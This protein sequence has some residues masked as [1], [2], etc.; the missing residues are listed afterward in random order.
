MGRAAYLA[1]VTAR[2]HPRLVLWRNRHLENAADDD[3]VLHHVVVVLV[4]TDW[5]AFEDKRGQ[6]L[7]PRPDEYDNKRPKRQ[8][9]T[10]SNSARGSV[11]V[12]IGRVAVLG[13]SD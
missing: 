8:G 13:A 6:R 9:A 11:S 1:V 5:C 10:A 2:P 4:P 7:A 3:A 12:K